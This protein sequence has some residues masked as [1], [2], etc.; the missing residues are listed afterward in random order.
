MVYDYTSYKISKETKIRT[1]KYKSKFVCELSTTIFFQ[2]LIKMVFT[3]QILT[4][5]TNKRQI[6]PV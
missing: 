2:S 1:F 3:I 6:S 4:I 5:I